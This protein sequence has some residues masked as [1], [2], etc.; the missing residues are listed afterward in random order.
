MEYPLTLR[1]GGEMYDRHDVAG[2]AGPGVE[3]VRRADLGGQHLVKRVQL[4]GCPRCG[5][6]LF[7][8]EDRDRRQPGKQCRCGNKDCGRTVRPQ[9]V[10]E[11]GRA[12]LL[13]LVMETQ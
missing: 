13:A 10:Q 6:P 9:L 12:E 3:Y 4:V 11:S 8:V 7:L 5:G 1:I 2:N